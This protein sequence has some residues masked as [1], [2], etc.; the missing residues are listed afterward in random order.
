[1]LILAMC[2]LHRMG[3]RSQQVDLSIWAYRLEN[4]GRGLQRC[5]ERHCANYRRISLDWNAKWAY[6]F[7][8]GELRSVDPAEGK[9]LFERDFF[10]PGRNGWQLVDR[11]IN[12]PRPRS[13]RQFDQLYGCGRTRQFYRPKP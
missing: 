10:A 6:P 12:E 2:N 1:M 4:S 7:R 9:I 3:G 11:N 5:A 8:R 13:E